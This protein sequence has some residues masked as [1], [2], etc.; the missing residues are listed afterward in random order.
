MKKLRK[1]DYKRFNKMSSMAFT[2]LVRTIDKDIVPGEF[3]VYFRRSII[4]AIFMGIYLLIFTA[5]S[6]PFVIVNLYIEKYV[7]RISRFAMFKHPIIMWSV[8]WTNYPLIW[9]RALFIKVVQFITYI[10][11][12]LLDVEEIKFVE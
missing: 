7:V 5:I 8:V 6:M 4:P 11:D 2:G 9:L 1:E 10:R 12:L 3:D